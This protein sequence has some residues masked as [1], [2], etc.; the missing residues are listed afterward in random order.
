MSDLDFSIPEIYRGQDI[1]QLKG[2]NIDQPKQILESYVRQFPIN[3]HR[4]TN[5]F[6]YGTANGQGKTALAW[7]V[8][9]KAKTP[10]M[11]AILKRDG[12]PDFIN[13]EQTRVNARSYSGL[14]IRFDKFLDLAAL[15]YDKEARSD[16]QAMA[17]LDIVLLDDVSEWALSANRHED[18]RAL[19]SFLK[20]RAENKRIT[21]IT[22][23]LDP[24]GF[25]LIMGNTAWSAL[26][27]SLLEVQFTGGDIRPH[28]QTLRQQ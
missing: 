12:T 11:H 22:S 21:V 28:L 3:R 5:L 13:A 24:K 15:K 19:T 8:L 7:Y 16:L 2:N 27:Q 6:L 9:E 14:G 4:G 10:N 26:N 1:S 25:Q 23:N 17:D 18:Q 20:E